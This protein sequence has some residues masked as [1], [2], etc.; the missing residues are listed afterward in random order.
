[1]LDKSI[2]K[3]FDN[4]RFSFEE[5]MTKNI[6]VIDFYVHKSKK[7]FI[8]IGIP[9]DYKIAQCLNYNFEI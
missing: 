2:L 7:D 8:D 3:S 5:W 9:L 6:K 4:D 1:M